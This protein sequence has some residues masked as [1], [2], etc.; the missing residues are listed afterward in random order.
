MTRVKLK[1]LNVPGGSIASETSVE[2]LN[3][4]PISSGIDPLNL[5]IGGGFL[6]G[7]VYMLSGEK[8]AG[9]STL[10][11][12]IMSGIQ[13]SS[14][15]CVHA[16]SESTLDFER[17]KTLGVD[18][19]S[20]IVSEESIQVL[21]S[22]FEW[23][24]LSM[25][26]LREHYAKNPIMLT[27]DTY[28]STITRAQL[29]S[30]GTSAKKDLGSLRKEMDQF[31]GGQQEEARIIKTKLKEMV[32][33]LNKNNAFLMLLS[34][35]YDNRDGFGAD[36]LVTS[37][38]HGLSHALSTHI[39]LVKR[40]KIYSSEH[41]KLAVGNTINISTVK[42]KQGPPHLSFNI[43][44][45]YSYG[46]SVGKAVHDFCV[47]KRLVGGGSWT[48]I[49]N[50]FGSKD[51]FKVQ[52]KTWYG[53]YY[54]GMENYAMYHWMYLLMTRFLA[55]MFPSLGERYNSMADTR[56]ADIKALLESGDMLMKPDKKYT[57]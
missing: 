33:I 15:I 44:L 12:S 7:R 11:G 36:K 54:Q 57:S 23:L 21:E 52:L 27:W 40:G 38:G 49:E 28:Q 8:S 56:E 41:E 4:E 14:G 6:P 34:Q 5:I 30:T 1:K 10:M 48:T 29:A 25:L 55:D 3:S 13:D 24:K 35:V 47:D 50:P 17:L 20:L 16:E 39:R 22:G 45:Y 32:H 42:N 51:V 18:I 43:P 46:F 2:Y 37:G 9:K 19:D 26:Y 31:A 53:E